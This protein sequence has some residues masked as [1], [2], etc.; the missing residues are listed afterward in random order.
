[1]VH[2]S[3]LRVSGVILASLPESTGVSAAGQVAGSGSEAGMCCSD[4]LRVQCEP[5]V[6]VAESFEDC[7]GLRGTVSGWR[8][9]DD[10][11]PPPPGQRAFWRKD[12]CF[13]GVIYHGHLEEL[14]LCISVFRRAYPASHV[15]F[16]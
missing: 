14:A 5:P 12:V 4:L 10:P 6:S 15:E 3:S 2:S 13:E 1:M 11:P 8:R 7:R 16:S 9:M